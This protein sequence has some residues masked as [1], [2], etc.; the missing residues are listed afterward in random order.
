MEKHEI[1]DIRKIDRSEIIN[2]IYYFENGKLVLKEEVYDIKGWNP[3]QIDLIIN[4]LY[5]LYERNGYFYGAFKN[6]NLIGVVALESKF[7]GK[8]EDQLQVVFLH[9]DQKYRDKG[10][11]QKLMEKAKLKAKELGAKKLYISATPSEHTIGFYLSLNCKLASEINPELYQL[12]PDDIHLE[13][14]L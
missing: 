10:L 6:S 12:E 11:G 8:N 7:I 3:K 9:V 4:N 1:D 2:R 5:S 14:E 13:L